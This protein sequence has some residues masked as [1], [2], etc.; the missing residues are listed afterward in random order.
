MR[1]EVQ[2]C[3]TCKATIPPGEEECPECGMN[4]RTGESFEMRKQ[5]AR[6]QVLHPEH[7]QTHFLLGFL[8]VFAIVTFI[9]FMYQRRYDDILEKN[10]T[11][12]A[13]YAAGIEEIDVMLGE[14]K[15][16]EAVRLGLDLIEEIEKEIVKTR[17]DYIIPGGAGAFYK[18]RDPGKR[19]RMERMIEKYR[20]KKTRFLLNF[21]DK[22]LWRLDK[23]PALV[24]K[25]EEEK[26]KEKEKLEQSGQSAGA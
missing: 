16:A 10:A 7:Y 6:E 8:L 26:K 20:K 4:V 23:Y 13:D 11:L 12:F 1:E 21:K 19:D 15:K 24:A 17:D 5:K 14:D 3:P 22:I 9:G 25:A 18:E 2:V